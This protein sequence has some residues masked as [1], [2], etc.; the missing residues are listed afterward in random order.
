MNRAETLDML[1]G[2]VATGDQSA[3]QRLYAATNGKL[4]GVILRIVGRRDLAEEVLQDTYLAIWDHAGDYRAER[5]SP[6]AWMATIGRNRAL[7]SRRGER[8]TVS[9]DDMENES[10]VADKSTATAIADLDWAGAGTDARRLQGCLETLEEGPRSCILLA[11]VEGYTHQELVKR[12]GS[13]LGTV[14]SWIRRGLASLK[15]CLTA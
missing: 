5:G 11:M 13:P 12:L 9:L 15:N 8:E 7:N 6:I 3:F 4:F 10:V 1:L 2:A 14:K